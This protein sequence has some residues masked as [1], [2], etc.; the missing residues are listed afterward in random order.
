MRPAPP[1]TPSRASARKKGKKREASPETPSRRG[2]EQRTLEHFFSPVPSP[3]HALNGRSKDG[4]TEALQVDLT[5]EDGFVEEAA[6]TPR[7]TFI[8]SD[9]KTR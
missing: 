7:W 1:A 5:T 3:K 8:L 4:V 9:T 6:G 2:A